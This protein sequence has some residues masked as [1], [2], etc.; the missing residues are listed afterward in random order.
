[1]VVTS[2]SYTNIDGVIVLFVLLFVLAPVVAALVLLIVFF[3]A[4]FVEFFGLMSGIDG[5]LN[6]RRHGLRV[7]NGL[8]RDVLRQRVGHY[9][10]WYRRYLHTPNSQVDENRKGTIAYA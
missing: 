2:G 3:A 10:N 6:Q 4:H 5:I 1:M 9:R 8:G 7:R